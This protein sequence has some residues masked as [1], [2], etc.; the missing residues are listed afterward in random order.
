MT[1]ILRRLNQ[2]QTI[3][4]AGRLTEAEAMC[5]DILRAAPNMPEAAAMLGFILG[6]LNRFEEARALLETA[7]AARG[8]VAHWHLELSQ[9]YRRGSRLEDAQVLA[10]KAVELAPADPRF[11]VGLARV[12]VE[13]GQQEAARDALLAAL[14]CAPEDVEAHLALAHLL[15]AEGEYLAGWEEYE[16]RFRAPRFQTSMPRF[17]GPV[18]NG[19]R[20][21]GRRVLVAADQGFGDAFQFCRY[22][23]HVAERCAGVV[24]LCRAPQIPVFS[25]LPGVESCVVSIADVGPYAAWCW[26]AS[27][28]R[29]FGTTPDTIPGGRA[30][31]SPDPARRATMAARLPAAGRRVGLVWAGNPENTTD[32]RRS[33]PL[34]ML[35]PLAEIEGLNLVSLQL[36]PPAADRAAMTGMGIFD[37]SAELIDFGETAAAIANLDLVVAVDSAVAHLAAAL[38]V[39][40]WILV[41]QPADWRWSIGREDSLWYPLARLF[42]QTRP[43]DWTDPIARLIAAARGLV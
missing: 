37:I 10:R 32:W 40:T 15:L 19:M 33:I 1:D 9:S 7:I 35:A 43:G 4:N 14:R 6:R 38:G 25:R 42:R 17:T 2:A 27:L 21:P 26:M 41:Y 24:V 11:H 36:Q 3:A 31:L 16:W 12:H 22:L 20:L 8:D 23:P 18:W 39:P 34:R 28:P 13:L 30:Y 5:R 29:L